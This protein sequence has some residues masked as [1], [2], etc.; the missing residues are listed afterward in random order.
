LISLHFVRSGCVLLRSF[1]FVCFGLISA[2]HAQLNNESRERFR[3]R[4]EN[5]DVQLCCVGR[6]GVGL[7]EAA[8]QTMLFVKA[9]RLGGEII[10]FR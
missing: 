3:S 7:P 5:K 2:G 8:G 6:I 4:C 10:G 1:S 9:S